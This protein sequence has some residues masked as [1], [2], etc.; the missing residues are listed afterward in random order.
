MHRAERAHG[1]GERVKNS[2]PRICVALRPRLV[3]N[4]ACIDEMC[5]E[6]AGDHDPNRRKGE[7]DAAA[8]G[9]APYAVSNPISNADVKPGQP[10]V[11]VKQDLENGDR[12]DNSNHGAQEQSEGNAAG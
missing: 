10:K 11:G 1:D 2:N 5:D 9:L 8:P 12:A 3:E 6:Q 7:T 4:V